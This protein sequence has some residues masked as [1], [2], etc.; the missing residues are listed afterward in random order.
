MFDKVLQSLKDG[1]IVGVDFTGITH[2]GAGSSRVH[3][4]VYSN[5]N[6]FIPILA[7]EASLSEGEVVKLIDAFGG[8]LWMHDDDYPELTA[9]VKVRYISAVEPFGCTFVAANQD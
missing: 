6:R 2:L 7:Y 8:K 5:H 1:Y 9:G 4:W 3:I